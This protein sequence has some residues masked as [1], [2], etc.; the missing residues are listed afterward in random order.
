MC[1]PGCLD[2]GC[3]GVIPL[4]LRARVMCL[5]HEGHLGI[6]KMKS[7]CRSYVWWS[8]IDRD[9]ELCAKNCTACIL[10]DKSVKPI[11]PPME[12]IVKINRGLK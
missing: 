1:G 4:S 10:S 6:V 7:C 5:A 2:R 11:I 9:L 3:G 8:A 12:V